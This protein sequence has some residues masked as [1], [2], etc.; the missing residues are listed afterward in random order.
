V[1]YSKVERKRSCNSNEDKATSQI[2]AK[3]A[4][5]AVERRYRENLNSEIMDLHLALLATEFGSWSSDGEDVKLSGLKKEEWGKIGVF[6]PWKWY[7]YLNYHL[8]RY[9]KGF[10][11]T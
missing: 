5:S 6:L 2:Q 10:L 9:P 4:H 1:P 7:K 11:L 8:S 3:K